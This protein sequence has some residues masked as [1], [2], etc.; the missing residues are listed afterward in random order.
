ME[1][2]NK[3]IIIARMM[4]NKQWFVHKSEYSPVNNGR[5]ITSWPAGELKNF[6]SPGLIFLNEFAP[7]PMVTSRA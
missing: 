5:K 2:N 3:V 6:R 7:L 4:E 1:M